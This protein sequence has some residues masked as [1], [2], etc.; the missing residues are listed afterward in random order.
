MNDNGARQFMIDIVYLEH[1]ILEL[2]FKLCEDIKNIISDIKNVLTIVMEKD[3]ESSKILFYKIFISDKDL[4]KI[5]SI[6][7]DKSN[8]FTNIFNNKNK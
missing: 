2:K 5:L 4:N 3:I 6:R 7:H 1:F 8:I